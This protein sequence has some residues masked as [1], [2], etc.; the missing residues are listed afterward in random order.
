MLHSLFLL[1]TAF[2]GGDEPPREA[3]DLS[4]LY[5]GNE[6]TP[7]TESWRQMLEPRVKSLRVMSLSKLE[8]K[9]LAGVDVLIVGGEV[10]EKDSNGKMKGLKSEKHELRF[11]ALQGFPVVLMG[12]QGGFVSDDWK[13]KT[14]WRHG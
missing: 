2:P 8:S 7:Y 4:V 5:A 10:E 11:D 9:E 1:I 14:S 13:L 6:G 3:L 12:G